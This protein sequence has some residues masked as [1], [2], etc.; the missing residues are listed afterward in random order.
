MNKA[1]NSKG[2]NELNRV[3]TNPENLIVSEGLLEA[4]SDDW[5]EDAYPSQKIS[6]ICQMN[7]STFQLRGELMSFSVKKNLKTIAVSCSSK[8]VTSL[9]TDNVLSSFS[10]ESVPSVNTFHEVYG[11][12]VIVDVQFEDQYN[13]LVLV[14]L[15]HHHNN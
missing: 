7:F 10:I 3:L 9:L 1:L 11:K 4:I 6:W 12:D 14:T 15:H 8:D 2:K 5:L 13:A